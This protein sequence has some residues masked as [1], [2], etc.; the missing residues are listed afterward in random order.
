MKLTGKKIAVLVEADYQDMEVWF[1][2]FRLR[3]EGAEV[4]V[5]GTGSSTTYRGKYGYPITVDFSADQVHA[6]QFHG[7]VIPGGWA[8]DRL[9]QYKT[10]LDFVRKLFDAGKPVA[11]ICHAGSV[12][13][14]ADLVRGKHLTSFNAIKDDLKN[15]GANWED[16]E[17]V[18]DGNLVTSRRP[19]DL[20]AFMREFIRLF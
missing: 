9:R 16:R 20:P 1:P 14:S 17:V 13:V 12:L 19:D 6:E 4:V 3:E 11:A 8:P 15:A 5:V 7:V 10:V 18:V 2:I